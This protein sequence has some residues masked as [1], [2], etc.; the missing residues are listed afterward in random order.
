MPRKAIATVA[1]GLLLAMTF[2]SPAGAA[3]ARMRQYAART[4]A[5]LAA[6]VDTPSG[7]P[8]DAL[9][10]DGGTSVQT[11]PTDIGAYLWSA[12]AAERLG[13]IS[14]AELRRRMSATLTSLEHM[15]RYGRPASTT[16]GT[17]T[18]RARS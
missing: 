9:S 14:A 11:S 6:M 15:E 13:I 8:A 4:W 17:T 16:T 10:S 12:V 3:Q 5:S 18:A 7:L 2:A 1:L